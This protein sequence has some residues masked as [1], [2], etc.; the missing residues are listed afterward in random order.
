MQRAQTTAGYTLLEICLALAVMAVIATLAIPATQGLLSEDHIRAV[1][2]Q[3]SN[4][5]REGQRRAVAEGMPYVITLNKDSLSLSPWGGDATRLSKPVAALKLEGNMSLELQS[6]S[7]GGKK[8]QKENFWVFQP[9][10]LSEPMQ[11]AIRSESSW[12]I[13]RYSLLTATVENETSSFQ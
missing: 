12:L 11:V 4:L 6:P 1:A 8:V 5:A 9:N 2:N 3:V 7:L 10:G 13:Q